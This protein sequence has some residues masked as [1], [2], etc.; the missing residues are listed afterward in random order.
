MGRGVAYVFVQVRSLGR[1]GP[2]IFAM[3]QYG[4]RTSTTCKSKSRKVHQSCTKIR[5]HEGSAVPGTRNKSHNSKVQSISLLAFF[6]IFCQVC[7]HFLCYFVQ[8]Y[9]AYDLPNLPGPACQVSR[10]D[11]VHVLPLI[12]FFLFFFVHPLS[13][14]SS[15]SLSLFPL[16]ETDDLGCLFWLVSPHPPPTL[17][18]ISTLDMWATKT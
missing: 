2:T 7:L 4:N 10:S 1:T 8:R 6:C 11:S 5:R 15:S 13:S 9:F 16:W 12:S 17:Q 18:D 14:S 3:D